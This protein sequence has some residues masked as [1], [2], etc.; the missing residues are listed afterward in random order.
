MKTLYALLAI[1]I[2]PFW[3]YAQNEVP[4]I[5]NVV[6]SI[7]T[8]I[9]SVNV[10]F[11]LIDTEGDLMEVWIQA[12]VDGGNT[13]VVPVLLDSLSG[14]YGMSVPSGTGKS[15][16]WAYDKTVLSNY[17][18]GLTDMRLRVIADDHVTIPLSEIVSKIDSSR[19]AST[20]LQYEGIRHHIANPVFKDQIKD[21][22]EGL[23]NAAGIYNY[24]Q[25]PVYNGYQ[26]AN[27]VGFS[28]GTRTPSNSWM[29][30]GHYDTVDDSPGADD[31]G[32]GMVAVAEAIR[33]L[34]EYKTKNSIRYYFFDLEEPGLIGSQEYVQT[35]IPFWENMQGLLNMDGIGYYSD[36][37]NTQSFP[38][39]FDLAYPAQY[40]AVVAD[41]SR[42][43]FTLSIYNTSSASLDFEFRDVAS[44]YVPDLKIIGFETPGTGTST[45][46]FRRS[47]HAPFWDNG[48]PALFLADGADYRNPHYHTPNDSIHTLDMAFL[49]NNIK[50]IVATLAKK[51][52]LEHS[53]CSESNSVQIELPLSL[54]EIN[55]NGSSFKIFPNPSV[56]T[57]TFQISIKA[58]GKVKMIIV[59]S[60]GK[61]I[62]ATATQWMPAGTSTIDHS[63][64]LSAG[65]YQVLLELNG[66]ISGSS[67]LIVGSK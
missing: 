57:R 55:S 37:A 61:L 5:T 22:L 49:I 14:D 26:M 23:F 30:S 66:S 8:S 52:E 28:S 54:S 46:D 34:S 7:D 17:S 41:S 29:T 27:I 18:V 11:D 36:E 51:A 24:R 15:I 44:T 53:G 39:G 13:W 10:V 38:F 31:N 19:I 45:P 32:T 50:A 16:T 62:D 2:V 6:A 64:E 58:A 9:Q 25:G 33:V 35:G 47:D 59:D 40:N 67:M 43:D 4:T 42:G 60:A 48:T 20:L 3:S 1:F 65:T 56:G 21:S 63:K 12:S